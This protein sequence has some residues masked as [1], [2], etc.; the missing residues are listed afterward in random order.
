MLEDKYIY[1]VVY[2]NY[3]PPEVDSIWD[4]DMCAANQAAV[5]G[6]IWRVAKFRVKRNEEL[7]ADMKHYHV[8]IT[9]N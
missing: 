8:T 9:T 3:D 4:C 1:M 5:L 7:H 2:G 6:D